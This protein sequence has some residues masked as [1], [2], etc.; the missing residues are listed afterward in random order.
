MR[1]QELQQEFQRDLLG[2][3]GGSVRTAI[4]DAPPRRRTPG[5]GSTGMHIA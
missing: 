5:W 1:L 2:G 3:S 4:V